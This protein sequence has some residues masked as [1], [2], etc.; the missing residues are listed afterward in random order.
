MLRN[1]LEASIPGLSGAEAD[2]LSGD[3]D[4]TLEILRA[5]EWWPKVEAET[6]TEDESEGE[7]VGESPSITS[8]S[9]PASPA[10]TD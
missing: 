10:S 7:A 8:V 3:D 5:L 2:T 1:I 6:D 4:H 9:S